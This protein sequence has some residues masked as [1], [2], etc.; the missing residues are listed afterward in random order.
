M[1]REDAYL[2]T[3]VIDPRRKIS[4]RARSDAFYVGLTTMSAMRASA[5]QWLQSGRWHEVCCWTSALFVPKCSERAVSGVGRTPPTGYRRRSVDWLGLWHQELW[6][7]QSVWR[8]KQIT[9][10]SRLLVC[11]ISPPRQWQGDNLRRLQS[12]QLQ[13]MLS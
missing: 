10:E 12:I 11:M 8:H 6:L 7:T 13:T 4:R 3:N 5:W 2:Y 9:S 1:W